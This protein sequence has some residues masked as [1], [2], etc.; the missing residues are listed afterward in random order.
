MQSEPSRAQQR[1]TA[2]RIGATIL[3]TLGAAFIITALIRPAMIGDLM[4]AAAAMM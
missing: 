2:F 3:A 1:A 4:H